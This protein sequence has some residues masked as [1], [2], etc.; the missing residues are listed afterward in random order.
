MITLCFLQ[1]EKGDPGANVST[2]DFMFFTFGS[3]SRLRFLVSVVVFLFL[4]GKDGS[5]GEPGPPGLPGRQVL[6]TS[7]VKLFT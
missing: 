3:L 1:G 7:E 6:V 2:F 4:Q 5:K